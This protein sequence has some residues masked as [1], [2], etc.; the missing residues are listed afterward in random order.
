MMISFLKATVIIFWSLFGLLVIHGFPPKVT[1]TSKC[2]VDAILPHI[3]AAKPT[4]DPG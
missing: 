1:L 3:V 2:F 4:G